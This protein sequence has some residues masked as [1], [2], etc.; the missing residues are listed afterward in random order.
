MTSHFCFNFTS[1][2]RFLDGKLGCSSRMSR[3]W[4]DTVYFVAYAFTFSNL[5]SD[6]KSAAHRWLS[7][8]LLRIASMTQEAYMQLAITALAVIGGLIFSFAISLLVEEL[9]F[10]RVFGL[11]FAHAAAIRV[12]SEQKR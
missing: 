9:I 2:G 1:A 3:V 6:L 11:F 5:I 10:G 7:N 4:G 8:C 12:K